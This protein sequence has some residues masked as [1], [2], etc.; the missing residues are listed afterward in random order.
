MDILPNDNYDHWTLMSALH[1]KE[2]QT[3]SYNS[4]QTW[5][6]VWL[7]SPWS[8]S[9]LFLSA[10]LQSRVAFF[11]WHFASE[12]NKCICLLQW[13][14]EYLASVKI[15]SL[16][17]LSPSPKINILEKEK[18]NHFTKCCLEHLLRT[19]GVSNKPEKEACLET[20]SQLGNH[21]KHAGLQHL[22]NTPLGIRDLYQPINRLGLHS[23]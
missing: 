8:F 14:E 10:S 2:Q 19:R 16:P 4:S 3:S 21:C 1:E 23:N 20:V 22:C 5:I 12:F 17:S 6:W 13:S 9:L 7:A 18:C 11:A 15:S